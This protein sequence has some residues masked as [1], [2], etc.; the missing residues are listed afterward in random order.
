[1][2]VKP[3]EDFYRS[4]RNLKNPDPPPF[5]NKM[6]KRMVFGQFEDPAKGAQRAT[7][8]RRISAILTERRMSLRKNSDA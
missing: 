1:M 3:F 4:V 8:E 6:G 5:K 7:A 2:L